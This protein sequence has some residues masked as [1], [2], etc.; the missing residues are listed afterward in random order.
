MEEIQE[1]ELEGEAEGEGGSLKEIVLVVK[2]RKIR[3]DR[4][5]LAIISKFFRA[6]FS[7]Q[8]EDSHK[9]VLHLDLGGEMG[10]TAAAVRIL[11]EFATTRRL[12][13]SSLTAVQ[14]FIAADALDVAAAR[15]EAETFLG[16]TMLRP[17]RETFL[18]FWRMS[19]LFHMRI[20]D[21]F[22][23]CLCLENF[24]WFCTA[25]PLLCPQYLAGWPL[26]KLGS[27]LGEQRF[28]N[29]SE[30]QIFSAVV[31]YC[32]TRTEQESWDQLAPGLYRSCGAYLR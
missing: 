15:E 10:L 21:T 14:T 26:D 31:S 6:L 28:A 25:L 11:A 8:F 12:T 24:G 17:E 13:I 5:N 30:E 2:G 7:H 18:T 22:L 3:V 1:E 9:A 27:F 4:G 16:S 19:R 29:C 23:D 20:L 32:R